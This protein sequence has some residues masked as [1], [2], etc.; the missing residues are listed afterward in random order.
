M[1]GSLS[2]S[3]S[4][5][6]NA[7]VA[8]VSVDRDRAEIRQHRADRPEHSRDDG[9]KRRKQRRDQRDRQPAE[10]DHRVARDQIVDRGG[11]NIDAG[12]RRCA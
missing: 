8:P 3:A 10:F 6:L 2:G 12:D 7:A 4:A 5:W 9:R 11:M 1:N